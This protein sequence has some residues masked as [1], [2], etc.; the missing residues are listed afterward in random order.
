VSGQQHSGVNTLEHDD[1]VR[2]ED[3]FRRAT[4]RWAQATKLM[5]ESS[6]A[7]GPN[8][9][10]AHSA[11]EDIEYARDLLLHLLMPKASKIPAAYADRPVA[12]TSREVR[13]SVV[14]LV[15]RAKAVTAPAEFFEDDEPVADVVA[16]FERANKTVTVLPMVRKTP[17]NARV[18][19][20]VPVCVV[21]ECVTLDSAPASV[22]TLKLKVH[23][24]ANLHAPVRSKGGK[25][26]W[27]DIDCPACPAKAS[28][29]CQKA[30]GEPI[31]KPHDPRKILANELAAKRVSMGASV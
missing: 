12:L 8:T 18:H 4:F 30:G 19:P 2:V 3:M 31:E 21:D 9:K 7:L 29:R 10:V 14:G 13:D 28:Q 23:P 1:G 26:L 16:A 27:A 11:L 25:M 24:V 6:V 5:V 17:F 20:R 22:L 15:D